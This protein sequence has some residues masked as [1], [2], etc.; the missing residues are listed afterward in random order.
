[1]FRAPGQIR[2]E[3][4]VVFSSLAGVL[5]QSLFIDST[6]WRHLW[7][8]L[9]LVWALIIATQRKDSSRQPGFTM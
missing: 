4:F 6:H 5:T 3:F 9:A 8:L 7:L 2:H 1:L